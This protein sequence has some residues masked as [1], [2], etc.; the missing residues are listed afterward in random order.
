LYK[1]YV[2]ELR[3]YL[4][5]GGGTVGLHLRMKDGVLQLHI[6]RS[7]ENGFVFNI[8]SFN[9]GTVF[10]PTLEQKSG[11]LTLIQDGLRV[12]D[13][14]YNI[15]FAQVN[16]GNYN[17]EMIESDVLETNV[18]SLEI[19]DGHFYMKPLKFD[20]ENLVVDEEY[21][22]KPTQPVSEGSRIPIIVVNPRTGQEN[23]FFN[24]DGHILSGKD[25]KVS[26]QTEEVVMALDMLG[27]MSQEQRNSIME[28][29]SYP[30]DGQMIGAYA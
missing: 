19:Y 25:K 21:D 7:G 6:N 26:K 9:P 24:V 2:E 28:I 22:K 23:V 18:N 30:R 16:K 17:Y 5:V 14:I 20:G 29:V 15:N 11:L 3:K 8:G 1:P 12:N 13:V 27:N 4:Y 10:T